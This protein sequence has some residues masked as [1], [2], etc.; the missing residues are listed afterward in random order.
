MAFYGIIRV[1]EFTVKRIK[2]FDPAIHVKPSDMQIVSDQRGFSTTVVFIPR[3]KS[4]PEGEDVYWARQEGSSDP[5]AA[6]DNHVVVGAEF[7]ACWFSTLSH[8]TLHSDWSR[9][10]TSPTGDERAIRPSDRQ[11]VQVRHWTFPLYSDSKLEEFGFGFGLGFSAFRISL[12][13]SISLPLD[14]HSD[15]R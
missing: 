10:P 13:L 7:L 5:V 9:G 15:E 6:W 14:A 8:I 11:C 2:D 12:Y 1:G 4:A 3:T